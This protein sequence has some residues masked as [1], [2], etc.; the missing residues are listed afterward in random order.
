MYRL[1]SEFR[2][3][4]RAKAAGYSRTMIPSDFNPHRKLANRA[5]ARRVLDD[6]IGQCS[7]L[8]RIF[9][10]SGEYY[11][12]ERKAF[13]DALAVLLAQS[14]DARAVL[15]VH[16][17]AHIE[18]N[19]PRLMRLLRRHTP[20]LVIRQTEPAVRSLVRGLV[21]ADHGVLISRPHFGQPGTF[22]DYDETAVST[23]VSLFAEIE[24]ATGHS[25]SGHVT[26]L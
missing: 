15:I 26:G 1:N 23:A 5:E 9:D 22:I 17:T 24:L 20:R 16:S 8:L 3:G 18:K 11:G 10:D 19:C 14:H 13:C 12:F 6:T 2:H 21:I 7:R 4:C 25:L